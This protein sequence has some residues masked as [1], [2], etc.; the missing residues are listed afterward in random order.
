MFKRGVGCVAIAIAIVST[1][2][3]FAAA[4]SVEMTWMSIANWYFKIGDTRIMMDAYITR[5][6]APPFFYAPPG[7][8]DDQYAYT[9]GAFGIDHDSI[10]KVREAVLGRDHDISNA[11]SH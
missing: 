3:P 10:N 6:P 9:K 7:Y 8:P 5:V 11:V 4:A 1:T 2:R